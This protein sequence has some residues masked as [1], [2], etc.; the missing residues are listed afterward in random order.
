MYTLFFSK[1]KVRSK[2]TKNKTV[3][4]GD[5]T[6]YGFAGTFETPQKY[7]PVII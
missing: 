2:K 3:S 6:E 1:E 5:D 7:D 4:D